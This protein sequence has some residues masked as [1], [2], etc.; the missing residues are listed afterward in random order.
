[1]GAKKR[2]QTGAPGVWALAGQ[3]HGVISRR[4]LDALGFGAKAVRHRLEVGRL[5]SQGQ[6]VY[7]VGRPGLSREGRWMAA[8]LACGDGAVL[9][10]GSAA[11]LWRIGR[12]RG[13]VEVS[14]PRASHL[15]RPG[16]TAHR[17]KRLYRPDV[18]ECNGIPVTSPAMTILD[19]GA[20]LG[21]GPLERMINEA[22]MRDLIKPEEL[23]AFLDTHPRQEG[24]GRLKDLMDRRA[25][26]FKTQ[27]ELERWFLPIA[28]RAGVP[29]PLTQ[30]R[31]N[32]FKV[33]FFWPALGLVVETDGLTYHRTPAEQA[34]DRV[35][36][37]AHTAA[38]LT[39]LRF[40]HDQVRHEPAQVRRVLAATARRLS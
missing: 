19:H 21:R 37:Q 27:T 31:V 23:R 38:G 29:A 20:R 7:S 22:D 16:L 26:R 14:V 5:H 30:H 17:R 9:S 33:D 28:A 25:F 10:H 11:A 4:Q 40:T 1:M 8:V 2:Q 3:Q 15:K 34:A 39:P 6:A 36:D 12:E 24:V 35:R 13:G 18:G 32:G